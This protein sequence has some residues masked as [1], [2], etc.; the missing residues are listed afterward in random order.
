M[1]SGYLDPAPQAAAFA[2]GAVDCWPKPLTMTALQERVAEVL[3]TQTGIG[4]PAASG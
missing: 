2:A 1:V 4:A 3:H